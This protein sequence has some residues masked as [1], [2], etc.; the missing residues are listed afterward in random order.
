MIQIYKYFPVR[1]DY[2]PVFQERLFLTLAGR[3][4]YN[5]YYNNDFNDKYML[6][7]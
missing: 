6:L 3:W 5:N 7:L 2:D 1:Q 4:K